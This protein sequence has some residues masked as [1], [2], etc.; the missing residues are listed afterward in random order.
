VEAEVTQLESTWKSEGN[1]QRRVTT[2]KRD[3]ETLA[4]FIARHNDEVE[5]AKAQWPPIA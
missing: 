1:I 4:Q 2:T 5:A 3:D